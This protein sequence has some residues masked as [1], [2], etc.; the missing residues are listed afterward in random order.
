[1]P[2][3]D[4]ASQVEVPDRPLSWA[5]SH[6]FVPRTFVQ[7]GLGFLRTEAAGGVVMLLAALVAIAVANSPLG[8]RYFEVFGTQIE[9][10][11]GGFH[12]HH[13]SELTVREWVNDGLMTIFFFVVGLEIKRELVVGDLR[14]PKAAA[15]PAI[16]A[17]G[18]M[19][20]PAAVYL[21][22]NVGLFADAGAPKGWGIP[23][24]TDIAFAV[25]IVSLVGR[26]VPVAA[27]L[28]LLALAIVD[29]LGAIIVIAL[30]YTAELSFGWLAAA[31][32]GLLVV[33]AMKRVDVRSVPAYILVGAFVWLATLES[34]VHAT[35]AGVALA[36]MT[37]VAAFY[38]P[39]RF[40]A[41]AAP[42][43]ARVE[44]YLPADRPL[45]E[46]DHHTVQRVQSIIDDLQRLSRE[47]LP[48]LAR[49]ESRLSSYASFL[50][51]P[52]F[53]FANAGVVVSGD[54]MRGAAGDPILLG[55]LVG[56]LGGKVVGVT[57]G[58][59][60]AVRLGI[61]RLPAHTTWRHVIGLGLL[62]GVG[63]TVALFVAALSFT[64][65]ANL[66][67]A[68]IGIFAGSLLAGVAGYVW[69]RRIPEVDTRPDEARVA[70]ALAH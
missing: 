37:H 28:F 51:V 38:D 47:S 59:W 53:A 62:A 23:M 66:D 1:V 13:L 20:V 26:R 70:G 55:V 67:S 31:A 64:D 17:L 32:V 22:F 54:A 24:A 5:E 49:L 11:F 45:H 14:D 44:A 46:A 50:V 4:G 8:D 27:K 29:D 6:R 60:L 19:A 7:P 34:G 2:T 9:I 12:F 25:G 36:L 52:L 61:G 21:L 57:A 48:P 56:L 3:T 33:H 41:A 30:F 58:A 68:K 15:L 63:F 18:G 10:A 40:A 69:L 35:V 16:A 43:V 42:L 39:A 65:P